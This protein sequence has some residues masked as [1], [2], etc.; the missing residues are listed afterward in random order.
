MDSLRQKGVLGEAF[1]VSPTGSSTNDT[2]VSTEYLQTDDEEE[3][4]TKCYV[5]GEKIFHPRT[6]T[7]KTAE[8]DGTCAIE[9]HKEHDIEKISKG[10]FVVET[11]QCILNSSLA[12]PD[13]RTIMMSYYFDPVFFITIFYNLKTFNAVIRWT[14]DNAESYFATINRVH[15]CAWHIFGR[16][17]DNVTDIVLKYYYQLAVKKWMPIYIENLSKKYSFAITSDNITNSNDPTSGELS[18]IIIKKFFSYEFFVSVMNKYID[19][20]KR[21]TDQRVKKHYRL[22]KNF[23]YEHLTDHIKDILKIK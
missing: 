2:P 18:Q 12:Y 13:E 3:C 4:L 22:I 1:N 15:N 7:F 21:D 14:N 6:L 17:K 20:I 10:Q 9:P 23:V 16:N 19:T 8:F 11:G 5:K